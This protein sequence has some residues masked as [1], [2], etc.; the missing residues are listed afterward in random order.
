MPEKHSPSATWF[1]MCLLK[2][3]WGE[4]CPSM[5]C[6]CHYQAYRNFI[7]LRNSHS[8]WKNDRTATSLPGAQA[9][10]SICGYFKGL[11]MSQEQH[12]NRQCQNPSLCCSLCFQIILTYTFLLMEFKPSFHCCNQGDI[13]KYNLF[14]DNKCAWEA[15]Y[16]YYEGFWFSVV[17][18]VQLRPLC[19]QLSG[20]AALWVMV[21]WL[22]LVAGSFA[23]LELKNPAETDVA[24]VWLRVQHWVS[25]F[26]L[27]EIKAEKCPLFP[28]S[29][30]FSFTVN[31]EFWWGAFWV[32][33][34]IV[35]Q[36]PAFA[37]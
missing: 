2:L 18:A 1:V 29:L 13:G 15:I 20:L 16:R 32:F 12:R 4:W 28:C 7:C 36:G 11:L 35:F 3:A 8:V 24:S 33:F 14:L 6:L 21:P 31:S 37:L 25:Q 9:W 27:L 34:T 26:H 19:V 17:E 22:S 23:P 10:K 5:L 30:L